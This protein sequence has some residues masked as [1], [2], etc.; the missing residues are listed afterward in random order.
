M[1]RG[2]GRV[3]GWRGRRITWFF[4]EVAG[5]ACLVDALNCWKRVGLWMGEVESVQNGM[6]ST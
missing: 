2:N 4:G 6:V 5:V 1:E 3:D